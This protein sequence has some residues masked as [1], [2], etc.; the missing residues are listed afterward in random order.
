MTTVNSQKYSKA[1]LEVA[2]EKGQL[3]NILAEVNELSQVFQNNQLAA[4]FA[5]EVYPE[6]AKSQVVDS[7]KNTASDLMKNFL[8]TI[9]LNGRLASLGDILE[10]IKNTADA[11][12]KIS[13]VE[14]LSSVKLTEEQI[15]KL[16]ALSKSKFD[17]N[18]VTIKNSV[19]ESILGGFIINA[20]G[21]IIDASIKTQLSKIAQQIL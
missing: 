15:A 6:A 8:D 19:D 20:R 7:L 2:R 14:V 16:T 11:M 18:E 1:L 17:L 3:D 5:N 4:F 9:R 13:D 12:F 10:E 21:K